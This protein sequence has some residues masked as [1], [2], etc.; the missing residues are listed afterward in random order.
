MEKL[1]VAYYRCS[2]KA[3]GQSG[4]GLDAQRETVLKYIHHNGNRLVSEFTEIESG[5]C[6]ERPAMKE[7]IRATISLG[8]V[9]VIA[10]LDRLSRNVSFIAN[11]MES[12]V[13]FIACDIPEASPLTIHIFAAIAEF[14]R[15][16]IS[17]RT[18]EALAAKRKREP[19]WKPGTNNFTMEGTSKGL[20]TIKK[21]AVEDKAWK[22]AW[23]FI[24]PLLDQGYSYQRIA[25][26][27]NDD[28]YRTRQGCLFQAAQVWTLEKRFKTRMVPDIAHKHS[29][30]SI[31]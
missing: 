9:L 8:A 20:S 28:G 22:H 19:D 6:N 2:T 12:G 11:L 17:E 1:F 3:Q 7:A 10:K 15:K 5:K 25:T 16:R 29:A 24:K 13:S 4:L 30:K 26:M 31:N 14:E 21:N 27:L 23:H 18:R